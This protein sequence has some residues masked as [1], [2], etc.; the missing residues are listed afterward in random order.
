MISRIGLNFKS[1][2]IICVI[3]IFCILCQ[4]TFHDTCFFSLLSVTKA[5]PVEVRFWC[6]F[7]QDVCITYL[8]K[9]SD[10]MMLC[11]NRSFYYIYNISFLF[12]NMGS[13]SFPLLT[14]VTI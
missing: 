14:L 3:F 10:Y 5:L 8:L 13:V 4:V 12:C 11:G 1:Y 2:A 7:L 6:R 9:V